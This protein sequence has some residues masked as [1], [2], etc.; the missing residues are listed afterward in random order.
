MDK[1]ILQPELGLENV[2]TKKRVQELQHNKVDGMNG[3]A[4]PLLLP[5]LVVSFAGC[6]F[7]SGDVIV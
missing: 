6:V 4:L 1:K 2:F 7:V 5:L 3:N